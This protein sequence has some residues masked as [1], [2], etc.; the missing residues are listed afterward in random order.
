[1]VASREL[2]QTWPNGI[3]LAFK[4]EMWCGHVVT[5][6]SNREKIL[7]FSKA[8]PTGSPVLL[9]LREAVIAM[10]CIKCVNPPEPLDWPRRKGGFLASRTPREM[11]K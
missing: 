1:M 11:L 8:S 5:I 9:E 7:D 3:R 10:G 6:W 4:Q 2:A